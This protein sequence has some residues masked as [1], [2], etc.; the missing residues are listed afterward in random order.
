MYQEDNF[1]SSL[2]KHFNQKFYTYIQQYS[3]PSKTLHD[4][5]MY[6]CLNSG[7]R[8]RPII[9]YGTGLLL[10]LDRDALD[11]IAIAIELMH[12]YSLVHDDLP[13]MD[14]DDMRRGKPSCHIAYNEATAILVGDALQSLSL[15]IL[16]DSVAIPSHLKAPLASSLLHLSG[17]KGMISGQ[18]LDLEL[19]ISPSLNLDQL[20][21]IHFL[22]TACMLKACVELPLIF[23]QEPQSS[24]RY[25]LLQSF[26][27]ELGIAFQMQDDYLDHYGKTNSLGKVHQSDKKNGK[28]T[29]VDF[30]EKNVL[31]ELIH[32]TFRKAKDQLLTI[33]T[34]KNTPL[35]EITSY[36]MN[37]H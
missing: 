16:L 17:A 1:F 19:L 7:K 10:H 18:Q 34:D 24:D 4:A 28:K 21:Q 23:N 12:T 15:S 22:K 32:D 25:R 30:Y 31:K 14:D 9:V 5:I 29:F 35:I 6:V 27:N 11:D 2:Q 20:N 33:S 13:A 8:L 3:I 26:A 36:L 37:R